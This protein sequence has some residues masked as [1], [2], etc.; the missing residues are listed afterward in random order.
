MGHGF[1]LFNDVA[2]R[3]FDTLPEEHR[4]YTGD[5]CPQSFQENCLRQQSGGSRTVPGDVAGFGRHFLDHLGAHVLVLIFQLDFPSYGYTVLGD[6]GRTKAF[7]QDDIAAARAQRYFDCLG[8]F[9]H[10]PGARLPVLPG[11]RRSSSQSWL[12][13]SSPRLA[14]R[15]LDGFL[16]RLAICEPLQTQLNFQRSISPK[17]STGIYRRCIGKQRRT[18]IS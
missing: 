1:Q 16:F 10:A 17:K 9:S 14:P 5:N 2:R 6:G 7:L 4:I 18:A 13:L 3:L 8:Q 11:Q 15:S 12:I